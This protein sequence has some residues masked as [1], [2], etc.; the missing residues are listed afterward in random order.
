MKELSHSQRLFQATDYWFSI[1]Q[2]REHSACSSSF[3]N[4]IIA[5]K[6]D[7]TGGGE[8]PGTPRSWPTPAISKELG[9]RPFIL[10]F[11]KVCVTKHLSQPFKKKK[12]LRKF[13]QNMWL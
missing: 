10:D 12:V 2:A 6:T 7:K 8:V 11:L 9:H 1:F 5:G 3:S 13:L 4:K